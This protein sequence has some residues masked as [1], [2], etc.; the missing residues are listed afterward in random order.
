MGFTFEA[1]TLLELGRELISD[2]EIALYE[3]IKNSVDAKSPKVVVD[4]HSQLAF[5]DFREALRRAR[6]TKAAIPELVTFVREK[7]T[8]AD[9]PEAMTFLK[10]LNAC[11]ERQAFIDALE[12]GYAS[13]NWI[14][15]RDTGEGMSLEDLETIFLRIGTRSRRRENEKGATNL[16]DKGIGRLS[17]MRLGGQLLVRTTRASDSNWNLLAI[18]WSDFSHERDQRVES[19]PVD[20]ELGD[21]KEDP[22]TSGT[23]IRIENLSADWDL[24]RF[25]ELLDGKISRFVDPFE[26]GLANKLIEARHNGQRVMIPAVPKALR[27]SAHAQ[28]TAR[29][30][31]DADGNP[32]IEGEIDYRL[33]KQ[34]TSIAVEGAEVMNVSKATKKR[35]AKRGHAAFKETPISLDALR[36]LKAFDLEVFWYNRRIIE[37]IEGLS[38]NA[39]ASKRELARWSGGPMLYRHGFRVLPFGEP[40]DDWLGLDKKAFG[41]SGF[42][43]NRQ[44][45]FGRVRIETPHR[46]LS[47]QTNREGLVQS[48]VSDALK[49]LVEWII[50]VEFRAFINEVDEAELIQFRKEELE[51]NQILRAEKALKRA[52]QSLRDEADGAFASEIE[53]IESTAG[54]LRDE[55][56]GVL[57]QLDRVREQA[58]DDREKFVYLAGVGLMTEF[59]FHELERAVSHTMTLISEM[60][61]SA[62]VVRTLSDQLQTLYKRIAAFDELTGEKRQTKTRFDLRDVIHEI[63]A[64]HEREFARHAIV[65]ELDLPDQPFTIRAVRGMVVQIVENLVVNA[66]YWLK[67]QAEYEDGFEP[68]LSI[69]IDADKRQLIVDDNG[70]GVPVDRRERI[71]QPFVTTKPS[72]MGKGLGLFIARDMAQYHDWSLLMDQRVGRIQPKRVNGFILQMS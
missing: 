46:Y 7:L 5:T 58:G 6:E 55:A 41:S 27:T 15:I 2:D 60:G 66:A 33:K 71:F 51:N 53:V 35:R 39:T 18:D 4:V 13:L 32:A 21:R 64:N 69:T 3:L 14:E 68:E 70:P 44:Q 24:V 63:V 19:I 42:K 12:D 48:E 72:G 50:N 30:F 28:C 10:V 22:S 52:V 1:R 20:P 49:R 9:L 47:E 36:K 59:I 11:K 45:V 37:G 16:G 25:T 67:R 8:D 31:F 23:T 61:S 40:D 54:L 26:K 43:L 65:L 29:F 17:A 62:P 38:E 57:K 34:K 56:L